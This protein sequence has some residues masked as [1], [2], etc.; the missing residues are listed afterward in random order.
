MRSQESMIIKTET[1]SERQKSFIF[2]YMVPLHGGSSH[3]RSSL[4]S[5][6][7]QNGV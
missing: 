3:D 4:V 1:I 7:I 6:A 5:E 2:S